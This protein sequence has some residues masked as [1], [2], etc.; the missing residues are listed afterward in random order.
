MVF[1][2]SQCH[3]AGASVDSRAR[4]TRQMPSW[5]ISADRAAMNGKEIRKIRVKIR[6][7]G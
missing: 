7:K 6:V 4:I 5:V 2:F 1:Y 3:I